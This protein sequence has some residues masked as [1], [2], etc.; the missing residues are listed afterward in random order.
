MK[1]SDLKVIRVLKEDIFGS[2]ALV[3]IEG[4]GRTAICRH[5]AG[6]N[7]LVRFLSYYLARR[8]AAALRRL[9]PIAGERIPELIHF[10]NGICVRGYIEGEPLR[11]AMV[12]DEG[13]YGSALDI[14]GKMHALGVVHNDLE[15][16]ENWLVTKDG[17]AAIIDFQL[18]FYSKRR[19]MLFRLAAR[20]DIRH[21]VKNKKRYCAS[22]LSEEEKGILENKSLVAR[23]VVK[24][25]KPV[26]NYITREV[27]NYSDRKRSKYSR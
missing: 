10:G 14:L 9:S 8:E 4:E 25:W 24:Y 5:Y 20:E 2:I 16:P 15:K 19:G 13:Y 3:E 27:L 17:A 6:A 26:Y 12:A 23:L 11:K 1:R 18:A 7:P 21:A 22:E